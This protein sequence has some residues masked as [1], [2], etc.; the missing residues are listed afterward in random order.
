MVNPGNTLEMRKVIVPFT[1]HLSC[2]D[3]TTIR[4]LLRNTILSSSLWSWIG[5]GPVLGLHASAAGDQ[6]VP[7]GGVHTVGLDGGPWG[8]GP[9]YHD[10]G[11]HPDH[12]HGYGHH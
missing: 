5:A 10:L 3:G 11:V 12:Y 1:L 9:I 4:S 2:G 8:P 7:G 6:V